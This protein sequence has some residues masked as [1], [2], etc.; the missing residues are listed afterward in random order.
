MAKEQSEKQQKLENKNGKKNNCMDTKSVKLARLLMRRW[1]HGQE[2]ETLK[3][4]TESL[5]TADQ[6]NAIRTMD[7]HI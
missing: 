2:K 5:L 4:E 6:N 3:K 1:G 7:P